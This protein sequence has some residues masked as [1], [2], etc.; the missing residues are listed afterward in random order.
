MYAHLTSYI[1]PDG[2]VPLLTIYIFLAV[3]LGGY[4]RAMGAAI[5]AVCLVTLLEGTRFLAA[6]I[7]GLS[8]VQVASLREL[9]IAVALIALMQWR[10][11]GVLR[12]KNELAV[13]GPPP[14]PIALRVVQQSPVQTQE[15]RECA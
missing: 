14:P 6:L 8:A 4:T 9:T 3:T 15:A 5:G 11:Q 1:A 10:P 12:E 13:A 2:F 7:P